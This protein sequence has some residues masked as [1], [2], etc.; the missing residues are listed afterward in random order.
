MEWGTWGDS[1]QRR[2]LVSCWVTEGPVM[3]ERDAVFLGTFWIIVDMTSSVFAFIVFLPSLVS[4]ILQP[5]S[6]NFRTSEFFFLIIGY[7]EVEFVEEEK[8]EEALGPVGGG[9]QQ[10]GQAFLIFRKVGQGWSRVQT[11][12]ALH[13][14]WDWATY[15][16]DGQRAGLISRARLLISLGW[17]LLRTLTLKWG[18][19]ILHFW[20][21]LVSPA[22]ETNQPYSKLQPV[23]H[24]G[25]SKN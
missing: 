10:R 2:L 16:S 21:H 17:E 22:D 6:L 25:T 12:W 14:C 9:S 8:I 4:P 3:C 19:E 5:G 13:V 7:L 18:C 15:S 23:T 11:P 24:P 20:K 1:P